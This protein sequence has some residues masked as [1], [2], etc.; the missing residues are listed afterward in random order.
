MD[1]CSMYNAA[2]HLKLH[3]IVVLYLIPYILIT[4]KIVSVNFFF[5]IQ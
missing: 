1:V 3:V 4:K 2:A 5:F